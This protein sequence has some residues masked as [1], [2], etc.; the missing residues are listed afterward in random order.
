MRSLLGSILVNVF[1]VY[2]KTIGEKFVP[3]NIDHIE[4]KLMTYL[5]Y[6]IHQNI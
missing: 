3:S 4:K 5:F 2:K 6:L 1:L